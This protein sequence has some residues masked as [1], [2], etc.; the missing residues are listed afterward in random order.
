[1][2]QCDVRSRSAQL[3]RGSKSRNHGLGVRLRH[4]KRAPA[5]EETARYRFESWVNWAR[6][7]AKCDRLGAVLESMRS[8]AAM[9]VRHVERILAHWPAKL[10]IGLLEGL[11]SVFR[12]VKRKAPGIEEPGRHGKHAPFRSLQV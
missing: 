7:R 11:S 6:V 2:E 9:V 5:G 4:R 1:M 3:T 8:V 10:T 12:T